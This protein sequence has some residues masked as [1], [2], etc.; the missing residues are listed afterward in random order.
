MPR[1]NKEFCAQMAARLEQLP[2]DACNMDS[3]VMGEAGDESA[4]KAGR[5]PECGTTACIAGFGIAEK[6]GIFSMALEHEK[7]KKEGYVGFEMRASEYFGLRMFPHLFYANEWPSKYKEIR[8]EEGDRK[9]MIAILK[10]LAS[11]TLDPDEM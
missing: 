6:E 1:L 10:D 7:C 9:G 11:G 5:I 4:V 8:R 2:D 3:F